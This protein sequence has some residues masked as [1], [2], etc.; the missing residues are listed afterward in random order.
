MYET[1]SELAATLAKLESGRLINPPPI[2]PEDDYWPG[3]MLGIQAAVGTAWWIATF[4]LY[5]KND[6]T[7]T[8]LMAL[9]GGS[10]LPI[11]WFWE[12][13]AEPN[14]IYNYFA[15]GLLFNFIFYLASSVIELIAWLFYLNN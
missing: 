1:N 10:I 2:M 7:N 14:G 6:S 13:V 4:M 8:D 12:R 15:M 3:L 11:G 9:N 5:L